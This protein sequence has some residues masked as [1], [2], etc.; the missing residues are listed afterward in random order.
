MP[1]QTPASAPRGTQKVS[2]SA[3]AAPARKPTTKQKKSASSPR[4]RPKKPNIF[5]RFLHGLVRRLYFG[6]KTLFK[7]ALFIP[8]LVFMVWFSYTVDRSGLFQGELAPRRIVDLMLQG[9][10]VSN[11]EQMNEIEREVVQLFAQDVPDTPEVIGIGSSRVLQFTRELVG[12]ESFFN[13][14][15]TGAEVRDNMTSYYKMVCYGKAPKVLIWS[16]DPWVLYGDEAAFD[17]RAD[18]K[19]YNEFLTKV[20]SSALTAVCCMTPHSGMPTPTRCAPLPP[21]PAPRSTAYIWKGSTR[22]PPSRKK[23]L[24]SLSSMRKTRAPR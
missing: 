18:E 19:L 4:R 9:Y 20:P 11:F 15:V 16:V 21:K 5:V 17:K 13:M 10:D 8:I 7:F 3:V 24:T 2:R 1:T 6:S 23:R 12:T 22:F 14:G